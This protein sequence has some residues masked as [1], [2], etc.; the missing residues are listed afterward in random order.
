ME[1]RM[2]LYR[3][4]TAALND[5]AE[6]VYDGNRERGFWANRLDFAT[7]MMLVVTELSEAVEAQRNKDWFS[8]N[9]KDVYTAEDFCTDVK[10]TVEDEL[11]DAI[12]RL[13]DYCGGEGID[14][15]GHVLAKL[16]YNETR[17]KLHGKQY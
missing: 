11:A 6:A 5:L 16:K 8:G 15:A 7:V 13:L 17:G 1:E 4:H 2:E 9:L 14:I 3:K 10:D 12:I